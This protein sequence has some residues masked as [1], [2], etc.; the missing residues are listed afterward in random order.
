MSDI[1]FSIKVEHSNGK[2]ANNVN[3]T[4]Y[5]NANLGGGSDSGYTN[6]SGWVYLSIYCIGGSFPG[7]VYINGNEV[8]RQS[9]SDGSTGSYTI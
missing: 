3:V 1:N 2:P 6:S 5:D 8:G 7:K 4:V 9:F